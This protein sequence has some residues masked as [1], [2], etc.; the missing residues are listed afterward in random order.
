[1]KPCLFWVISSSMFLISSCLL[2]ISSSREANS[3]CLFVTSAS[4]AFSPFSSSI[5]LDFS[6]SKVALSSSSFLTFSSSSPSLAASSCSFDSRLE[7]FCSTSSVLRLRSS[8]FSLNCS[9]CFCITSQ[10]DGS[11]PKGIPP[12]N[13][14]YIDCGYVY[15][16]SA[17]W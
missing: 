8:S 10:I 1:M 11:S 13:S 7:V 16:L 5:I 3:F 14:F 15:R 2:R 12:N 17:F 4:R 6:D 9:A